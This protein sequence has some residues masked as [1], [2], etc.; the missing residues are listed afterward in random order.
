[1]PDLEV[2]STIAGTVWKIV[3]AVGDAVVEDAP[4]MILESMKMEIPLTAPE[5]GTIVA[6]RVAEGDSI[7]EGDVAI[8]LRT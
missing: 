2:K 1:M 8:I 4:L 3:T 6:F 7:A 5:D